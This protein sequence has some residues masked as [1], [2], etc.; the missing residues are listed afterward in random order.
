MQPADRLLGLIPR[1]KEAHV[2]VDE[3]TGLLMAKPGLPD[4]VDSVFIRDSGAELA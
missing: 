3:L 2:W 4:V 1:S